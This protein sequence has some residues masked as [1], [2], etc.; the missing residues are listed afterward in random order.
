MLFITTGDRYQ[1]S[2]LAQ[3][4]S[5]HIGKVLRINPQGG[6]ASGNPAING[7]QAEIWSYGHRNIQSAALAADGSLWTVEHGARGG[8]E[9]NQPQAGLNYGWPIITYGVEYSG[10]EI[11]DGITA[12]ESMEQ[13]VYYWDPVIA[14]SGMA[15]YRGD[16]FADWQNDILIGGLASQSLIRLRLKDG[17]VIGEARYLQGEQ[18]RI[19]DVAIAQDGAIMIL[20]DDSN[21]KLLR[22]TPRE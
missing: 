1:A 20:T 10:R 3:D 18:G 11:G 19:R 21:G 22:I 2:S 6:A 8:D 16:L 12:H 9:L 15:F 4:V 7:A 5:T 14:P 17:Q 13:P